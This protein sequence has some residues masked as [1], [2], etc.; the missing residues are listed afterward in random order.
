MNAFVK[1][2]N[3]PFRFR[4]FLLTKVPS[5]YFAGVRIK[6]ISPDKC[7]VTVP[8]KWFSTNPF[9]STYFACLAMAAEMSTG[10]LAMAQVY[11]RKPSISMLITDMTAEYYKKATGIT[12]FVCRDGIALRDAVEEAIAT[13]GSNIIT[14]KSSGTNAA[15]EMVAHFTFTWSLKVR[16]KKTG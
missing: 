3:N 15:G 13:D 8:Y 4:L 7:V 2:V 5:A 9:R 14:V 10:A 12:T 16:Q 1:M 6:S 11:K